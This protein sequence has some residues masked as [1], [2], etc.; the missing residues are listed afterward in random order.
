MLQSAHNARE[1]RA[2]TPSGQEFDSLERAARLH[3]SLRRIVRFFLQALAFIALIS[4]FFFRIPGA[5]GRSMQPNIAGGNHVLIDT[6][7]YG[8]ALGPLMLGNGHIH[9]GDIVAFERGQ[10]DERKIFLKRVIALPGERVAMSNGNVLVN[11]AVLREDYDPLPDHST[12]PAL[13]VPDGTVFVLGDNRAESDDSRSFGPV[14]QSS[15]IGKAVLII[16]PLGHV[17]PIR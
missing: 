1:A 10:A 16:W 9:R 8:V 5:E 14:A 11:G 17:K 2:P 15:I 7:A 4:V 13:K 6:L 3:R 12:T